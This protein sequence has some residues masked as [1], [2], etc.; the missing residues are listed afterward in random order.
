VKIRNTDRSFG[1]IAI[2]FHWLMAGLFFLQ[3]WI[4][5]TMESEPDHAL[6]AMLLSRHISLGFLILLLWSLRALWTLTSRRP[7]LPM[8]MDPSERLLARISHWLLFFLLAI[9][10]LTGWSIL[11]TLQQLFALPIHIFGDIEVPRLPLAA[12]HHASGLWM[13]LHAFLAYF[14]L[15]LAAVHGLAA[16]RHQF[17]RKDG[18]LMRMILPGRALN[19]D[20]QDD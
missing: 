11:S 7:A 19:T 14:M 12:T 18:L 6:K 15:V 1:V 5:L 3:F 10:P 4:G 17:T 16:I 20:F 9:T 8:H 13:T 2:I